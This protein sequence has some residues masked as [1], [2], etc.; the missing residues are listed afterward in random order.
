VKDPEAYY[1]EFLSDLADRIAR[2]LVEIRLCDEAAGAAIG[3]SLADEVCE[4]WHGQTVNVPKAALYK[5]H[6]RWNRIWEQFNGANH[7]EL[8]RT[9][10]M[11]V[12]QIY[13]ILK[14]MQTYHRT[15]GQDLFAPANG[16]AATA[17]AIYKGADEHAD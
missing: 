8:A 9:H 12:K 5:V 14:Y 17:R 13:K 11:G 10:G 15:R 7:A 1:P 16:V 4:D 2:H 6:V 3:R